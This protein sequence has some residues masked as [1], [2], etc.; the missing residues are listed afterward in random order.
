M[1]RPRR[2]ATTNIMRRPRLDQ[3]DCLAEPNDAESASKVDVADN[4]V[5]RRY[6]ST[7]SVGPGD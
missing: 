4:Q 1:L 7:W 6:V 3:R 2:V 5:R